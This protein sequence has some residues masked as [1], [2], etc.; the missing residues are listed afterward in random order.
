MTAIEA[1]DATDAP[2]ASEAG[3]YDAFISYS[4]ADSSFAVDQLCE[5]LRT[6]GKEVWLD[7]DITGGAKWQERVRRGIEA[8]KSVIFVVSPASV[9]SEACG[10]ELADAVSLNKLIIPVVHQDVP[11]N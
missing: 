3:R 2:R 7:L 9:A 8:C 5:Q 6:R 1:T 11:A 4:R 10:H